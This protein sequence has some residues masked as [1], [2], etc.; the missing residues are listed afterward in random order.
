MKLKDTT[1]M[2]RH[3]LLGATIG[4][5][6]AAAAVI[7]GQSPAEIAAKATPTANDDQP[8]G[9]RITPHIAQYYDTT[10]I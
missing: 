7:T 4:T 2:R 6:A 8:A 9:Y 10:K 5:A 1:P 3:F